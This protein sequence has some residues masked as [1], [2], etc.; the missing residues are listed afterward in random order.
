MIKIDADMKIR[1]L[2]QKKDSGALE[3]ELLLYD[4]KHNKYAKALSE[5]TQ[6]TFLSD[7]KIMPYYQKQRKLIYE[8]RDTLLKKG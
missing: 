8:Q 4:N 7:S 2:N 3:K 5:F 6:G 1:R